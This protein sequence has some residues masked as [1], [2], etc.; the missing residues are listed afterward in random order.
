MGQVES[1]ARFTGE[2]G[3]I[4]ERFH[5]SMASALDG[6]A[7]LLRGEA[8][9]NVPAVVRSAGARANLSASGIPL[10]CFMVGIGNRR[11]PRSSDLRL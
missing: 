11:S 9:P 2:Y 1:G 7:A 6:L 8:R 3:D 5:S 10:G 4:D